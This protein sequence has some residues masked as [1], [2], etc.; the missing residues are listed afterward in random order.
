MR[1]FGLTQSTLN[2]GSGDTRFGPLPVFVCDGKH[3][4]SLA[5]RRAQ[6]HREGEQGKQQ[7]RGAEVVRGGHRQWQRK[8]DVADPQ[9]HLRDQ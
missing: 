8:H 1:A 3:A 9:A 6:A 4:R 2:S 5:W 7:Q